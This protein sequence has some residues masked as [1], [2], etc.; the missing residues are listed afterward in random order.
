MKKLFSLKKLSEYVGDNKDDI[1]EMINVFIDTTEPEVSK[2]KE[3]AE[4]L[5]WESVYKIAHK[6]K[7]SFKVFE[8]DEMIEIIDSIELQASQNNKDANLDSKLNEF[9]EK[10][11]EIVS[12]LRNEIQ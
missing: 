10:F 3:L 7:P 4:K 2:L 9:S 5:E 1:K 8:M 6:I 12:L 11:N